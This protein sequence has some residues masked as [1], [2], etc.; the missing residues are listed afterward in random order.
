MTSDQ[1]GHE[2]EQITPDMQERQRQIG[3]VLLQ[4][5]L[6]GNRSVSECAEHLRTSR[7]RYSAIERGESGIYAVELEAIARFLAIPLARIWPEDPLPPADM[8]ITVK[9]RPG[10]VVRIVVDVQ[11]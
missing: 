4:A 11:E 9:P 3:A 10:E 6:D 1:G 7:R 8:V 5:R 2:A